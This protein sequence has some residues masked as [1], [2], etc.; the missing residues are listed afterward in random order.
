MKTFIALDPG[1]HV[2]YGARFVDNICVS[3]HEFD[4]LF[5]PAGGRSAYPIAVVEKPNINTETPNWQ[6]VLDVGWSGALV[7]GALGVS[8]TS[9][10]PSVWKGSIKKPMHH[11]RVWM[12]MTYAERKLFPDNARI[13][14]DTARQRIATFGKVTGYSQKWHNHLDALALG[15]FYLGRIKRGGIKGQTHVELDHP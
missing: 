2:V 15:L 9:F 6:S 10:E 4:P 14:I 5:I 12:M 8:V 3:L 1:K 13:V 11:G 7:A